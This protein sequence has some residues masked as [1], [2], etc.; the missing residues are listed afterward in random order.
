MLALTGARSAEL[1]A[2]PRDDHRNGLRWSDVNLEDGVAT[3]FGKTREVQAI[4]LLERVQQALE[5][6]RNVLEPAT[7]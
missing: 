7:E 3:V 4:P 5:A 2:D 1:F 6:Y